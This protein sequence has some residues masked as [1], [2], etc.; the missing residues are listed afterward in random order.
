LKRGRGRPLGFRLSEESKRAISESK[1]G[2]KHS[3]ATKEKISRTLMAYFRM[4][5]PLSKEFYDDYKVLIDS[6]IEVKKWYEDNISSLDASPEILTEKSL[7]AKRQRELSI[8]LNID[9]SSNININAFVNN[10]EKM[11]ELRLLCQQKGIDYKAILLLLD[12]EL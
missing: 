7:N 10:P 9:M 5:H 1:K 4:L 2:Q 6:D 3:E 12:K 11:C 8:E